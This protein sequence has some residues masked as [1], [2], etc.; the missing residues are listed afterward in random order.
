MRFQCHQD[1]EK[2]KDIQNGKYCDVCSKNVIDFTN[3]LKSDVVSENRNNPNLCGIYLAEHT[4][5]N[6]RGEVVDTFKN[7][8]LKYVAGLTFLVGSNYVSAQNKGYQTKQVIINS[9][10]NTVCVKSK[11][12]TLQKPEEIESCSSNDIHNKRNKK[13]NKKKLFFSRKFPFVVYR[14]R[15]I[16]GRF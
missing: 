1:L 11:E 12:D 5:D 16:S 2:M 13:Y 7:K 14:R 9:E 4:D 8:W 6:L 10:I 3:S 15:Y